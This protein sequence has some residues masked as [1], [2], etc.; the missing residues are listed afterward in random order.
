MT[1]F[2]LV[3]GYW[4][5][6]SYITVKIINISEKYLPW[7]KIGLDK[8]GIERITEAKL[9]LHNDSSPSHLHSEPES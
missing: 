4:P 7:V 1:K 9:L 8:N 3:G 6:P 2:L 5:E